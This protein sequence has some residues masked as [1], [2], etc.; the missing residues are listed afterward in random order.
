VLRERN[1]EQPL[2]LEFLRGL[3]EPSRV[4]DQLAD[5]EPAGDGA[6]T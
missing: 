2:A 4:I 6:Q 3:P 5:V 1:D